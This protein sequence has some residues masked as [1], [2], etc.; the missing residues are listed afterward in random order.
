MLRKAEAV[1]VTPCDICRTASTGV[2]WG[3][4]LCGQ[5]IAAWDADPRFFAKAVDEGAGLDWFVP[6]TLAMF[7]RSNAEYQRRT[8]AW[9]AE[10][11]VAS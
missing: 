1:V 4:E 2:V 9:V 3:H 8:D 7:D 10:I 11:G 6:T 5:C